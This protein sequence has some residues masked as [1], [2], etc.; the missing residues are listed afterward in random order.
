MQIDIGNEARDKY[1]NPFLPAT[2]IFG[3]VCVGLIVLAVY[4]FVDNSNKYELLA[5]MQAT[6]DS[7]KL[8]NNENSKATVDD[9]VPEISTPNSDGGSYLEMPN[10]GVKIPLSENILE[11]IQLVELDDSSYRIDVKSITNYRKQGFCSNGGSGAIGIVRKNIVSIET[12]SVGGDTSAHR[13]KSQWSDNYIT[14]LNHGVVYPNSYV[15]FDNLDAVCRDDGAG[16]K[17]RSAE[18]A[19]DVQEINNALE[20][21]LLNAKSM[22]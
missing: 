3:I 15:T 4:L 1:K 18:V 16:G 13:I 14:T 19:K 22:Q 6:I 17:E 9:N 12:V 7:L 8:S 21:A 5:Q 10:V 2:I 20:R 11:K